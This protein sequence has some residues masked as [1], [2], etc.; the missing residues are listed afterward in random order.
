MV[1]RAVASVIPWL[2]KINSVRR[3]LLEGYTDIRKGLPSD[4]AFS[5]RMAHIEGK[6]EFGGKAHGIWKMQAGTVIA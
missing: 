2:D 3:R 5:Q 4:A 6:F 1:A